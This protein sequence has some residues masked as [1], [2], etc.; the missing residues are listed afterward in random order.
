VPVKRKGLC[1]KLLSHGYI[2]GRVIGKSETNNYATVFQLEAQGGGGRTLAAKCVE[3]EGYLTGVLSREYKIL[4]T[5]AHPNIVKVHELIRASEGSALL[6][7]L[8]HGQ[9]LSKQIGTLAEQHRY[10]IVE[11][12]L[13]A[14]VYLHITH[15]I[16]HKDI[17]L[18]NIIV[19][20]TA[21][22]ESGA[23]ARMIVVKLIDF[24]SA[25]FLDKSVV[26]NSA[27]THGDD[28]A[29]LESDSDWSDTSDTSSFNDF[30]SRIVPPPSDRGRGS[31]CQLDIY[32]L[33]LVMAGL[34]SG[35]A[36][37]TRDVFSSTY[38]LQLDSWHSVLT[39]EYVVA[40]LSRTPDMRP[41]AL[42]AH[43]MLPQEQHWASVTADI[44]AERVW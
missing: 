19:D 37:F 20:T 29:E 16:A 17:K 10:C 35:R 44:A 36:M 30:D 22:Q 14:L 43:A 40:L 1:E 9:A 5:L 39:R 32:A 24:G 7:E 11:Q 41:D 42:T 38:D 15:Q 8:C 3:K 6:M 31:P 27:D 25:C 34:L 12:A 21:S 26:K 33:G 2:K 28:S 18:E 4:Q 13:S 23:D